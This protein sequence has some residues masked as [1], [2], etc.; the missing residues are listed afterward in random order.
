MTPVLI[1]GLV[2]LVA[3]AAT[4]PT[5]VAA[6]RNRLGAVSTADF[7][8]FTPEVR[9]RVVQN[10]TAHESGGKPWAVNANT[11]RFKDPPGPG[12]SWGILQW[13]QKSGHLGRVLDACRATNPVEFDR[14]VGGTA[15]AQELI[16]VCKQGG[17]PNVT[18]NG[19]LL[20]D[21]AWVKVF[22]ALGRVTAFGEVQAWY[23]ANGAHMKA[24]AQVCVLLGLESER[25]LALAFDRATQQGEGWVVKAA[26]E[27]AGRWYAAGFPAYE[28]RLKAL[29]DAALSRARGNPW[30][31]TVKE[32][33]QSVF[34]S[35]TLSDSSLKA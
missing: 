28:E 26:K 17:N 23:A 35:R 18:V 15:I 34:N 7:G 24:A 4:E 33:V 31:S 11:E 32:R 1:A 3:W 14:I 5:A 22:D 2:G 20:W 29:A 30:E 10:T 9:F 13:T 16:R 8:P 12:V 25:G 6:V 21:P 19:R 27:L